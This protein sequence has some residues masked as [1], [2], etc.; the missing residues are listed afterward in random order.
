MSCLP[1]A[2]LLKVK[3]L[4]HAAQIPSGVTAPTSK[5]VSV[6]MHFLSITGTL[7]PPTYH[8][9]SPVSSLPSFALLLAVS[10]CRRWS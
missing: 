4:P 10:L 6:A 2:V 7:S 1:L 3:H 8:T 9:F 5:Q